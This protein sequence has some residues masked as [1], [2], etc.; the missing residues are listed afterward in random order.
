MFPE[1]VQSDVVL[2]NARGVYDQAMAETVIG[3][4]L[5]F[6]TGLVADLRRGWRIHEHPPNRVVADSTLLVVGAGSV[7]HAVGRAARAFGMRVLGVA[8]HAHNGDE[9]FERVAPVAELGELLAVADVVVDTVPLTPESHHLFDS[10]AFRVM[11]KDALFV[12]IGRGR[13]V[14]EEAIVHAL[15][16]GE[17]GGAALDVFEV[18][19]LPPSSPLWEMDNV[20]VSPHVAGSAEGWQQ[21]LLRLS[22]STSR[23]IERGGRF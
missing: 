18:E 21:T 1:L 17:I 22:N 8:R 16:S 13:T 9:V 3:F 7:G 11:R 20:I 14:D 5:A 10:D 12:N 19:P 15:R 2:T 6:N 4:I 23:D